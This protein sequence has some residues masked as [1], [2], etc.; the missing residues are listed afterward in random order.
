MHRRC[1][2]R[3]NATTRA[4]MPSVFSHAGFCGGYGPASCAAAT[5]DSW[6]CSARIRRCSA[7]VS[8][9]RCLQLA[10]STWPQP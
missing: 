7:R 1:G 9:R 4:P 6:A 5:A 3:D 10:A 8:Q 2:R